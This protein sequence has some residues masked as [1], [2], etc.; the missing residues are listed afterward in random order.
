MINKLLNKENY[1]DRFF[2]AIR[3]LQNRPVICIDP[4]PMLATAGFENSF[5]IETSH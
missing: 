5:M 4:L 3:L 2:A 1:S